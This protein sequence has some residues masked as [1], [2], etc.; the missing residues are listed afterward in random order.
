MWPTETFHS[1]SIEVAQFTDYQRH[2]PS[3]LVTSCFRCTCYVSDSVNS[4]NAFFCML[5]S[6][7]RAGVKNFFFWDS[8]NLCLVFNLCFRSH[9]QV[10]QRPG[11]D[12]MKCFFRV[13][14]MPKDPMELLRRDAV[15]FEY[16]Y[17]QVCFTCHHALPIIS[18]LL[19][20][21]TA[22]KKR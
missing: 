13:S 21:L 1:N 18:L 7:A 19:L 22:C 8:I 10:T 12:K 11:S 3:L 9:V 4:V 6:I 14:F 17:L 20:K 15:A 16:L 5:I 2:V